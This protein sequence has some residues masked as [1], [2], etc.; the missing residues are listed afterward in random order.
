[1]AGQSKLTA[2]RQAAEDMARGAFRCAGRLLSGLVVWIM[3]I[4]VVALMAIALTGRFNFHTGSGLIPDE[5]KIATDGKQP[6]VAVKFY[7][8][9]GY[10]NVVKQAHERGRDVLLDFRTLNSAWLEAYPSTPFWLE[11]VHSPPSRANLGNGVVPVIRLKAIVDET[12]F[13]E[14][15]PYLEDLR[16]VILDG[17]GSGCGRLRR[18]GYQVQPAELGANLSPSSRDN[19]ESAVDVGSAEAARRPAVQF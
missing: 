10:L 6:L 3:P 7:Y 11:Q 14:L 2:T 19:N 4:V 18:S 12:N 13:A 5:D 8:S 17:D 16:S 15:R 1:M 9:A